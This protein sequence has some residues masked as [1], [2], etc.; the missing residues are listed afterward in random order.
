MCAETL[1]DKY[2]LQNVLENDGCKK[3]EE[4]TIRKKKKQETGEVGELESW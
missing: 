1:K 2:I 4:L 3:N